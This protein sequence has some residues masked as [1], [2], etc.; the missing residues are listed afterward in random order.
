MTP[1][2]SLPGQGVPLS[3]LSTTLR[4]H[5]LL[6]AELTFLAICVRLIGLLEPFVFQVVIDRILPFQREASLIVV[7]VVLIGANLFSLGFNL[8]AAFLGVSVANRLTSELGRRL[9]DHLFR[10]PLRH[11]RRWPVGETLSR[12]G[13]TDTIR[14]FLIGVTTGASLDLLFIGVYFMVLLSISGK[15]TMV[16]AFAVPLQALLYMCFGPVLRKRLRAQFDAGSHHQARMV[17]NLSGMTAVKAM[18]AEGAMLSRLS[19]TL[20]Q[21]LNASRRVY[22]MNAV[23]GQLIGLC[24]KGIFIGV[25]YI[26]AQQVFAGELTLGQLIAFQLIAEK[27]A[28]P[29]A[30]FS[31][32]WQDWQ[33]LRISRQRLGDILNSEQEKFGSGS[34][35]PDDIEPRLAFQGVSFGYGPDEPPV[36]SGLDLSLE[37]RTCTLVV[38]PSG[39]GKSTFGR[40]AAGLEEPQSGIITVGG[41]DLA[42]F[43]PES[44]RS[45]VVYV[46]QEPYLFSGTLRENLLLRTPD[47]SDAEILDAL[48]ISAAGELVFRLAQGLDTEVGERGS[49]LSGGQKQRVAIARAILQKP[50]ILILDEPTSALDEAAQHRLVSELMQLRKQLTVIVIT[51]RPDVF[52]G[53]D[54]VIDFGLGKH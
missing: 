37:P 25:I 19:E 31:K 4:K 15:L 26:G 9:F 3:W 36:I 39:I 18:T 52:A 32:L 49:A 46:P 5:S 7:I 38:G 33:N 12:I 43:E 10:L 27:I 48:R 50:A 35:F 21:T 2:T 24:E 22:T 17:E 23:S 14:G 29:I 30:G 40:L 13:E 11:F 41:Q 34:V 47:A 8:L 42:A 54:R 44:L 53:A 28:A 1:N 51:H 45:R 16:V 20:A 6:Y